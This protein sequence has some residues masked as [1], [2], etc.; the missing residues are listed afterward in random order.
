[1]LRPGFAQRSYFNWG[2]KELYRRIEEL[3]GHGYDEWEIINLFVD[4]MEKAACDNKNNAY[5]F[6]CAADAGNY[7]LDGFYPVYI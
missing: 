5:M 6:S 1:M 3:D 2:L 4:E 7:V